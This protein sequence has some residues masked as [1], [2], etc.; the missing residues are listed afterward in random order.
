M[1]APPVGVACSADAAYGPFVYLGDFSEGS[2]VYTAN[3]SSYQYLLVDGVPTEVTTYKPF[4]LYKTASKLLWTIGTALAATADDP[5]GSIVALQAD[6][7]THYLCPA[8]VP[9][10]LQTCSIPG[11][12]NETIVE[13]RLLLDCP[14]PPSPPH[15]PFLYLAPVPSPP[16]APPPP[17]TAKKT[18]Q[19]TAA[20]VAPIIVIA[21]AAL[22]I[23]GVL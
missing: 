15:L 20:I 6:N 7:E 10:W 18:H 3:R 9:Q 12:V 23:V 17:T 16:P 4:F 14:S 11:K 2:P 21:G 19:L 8:Q 22:F 1:E 5:S 13:T